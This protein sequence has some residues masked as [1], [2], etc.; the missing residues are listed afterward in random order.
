MNLRIVRITVLFILFAINS[1]F[2]FQTTQFFVQ[3]RITTPVDSEAALTIDSKIKSKSGIIESRTDHVTSTYFCLL[4]A[5]A[6][7]TKED[8]ENWFAKLGYSISCYSRGMQNE[9]MMIS[10]HILKDCVEEEK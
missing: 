5:D 9:D 6:D 3:F 1:S 2:I 4:S 7:Y 10:P 8:F